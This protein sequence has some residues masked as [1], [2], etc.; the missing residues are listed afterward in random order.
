M[1]LGGDGITGEHPCQLPYPLLFRQKSKRRLGPSV[2]DALHNQKVIGAPGSYLRQV[3]DT[4]DL[5]MSG[6]LLDLS[7][8]RLCRLPSDAGIDFVKDNRLDHIPPG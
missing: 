1:G 3:G 6:Q 8:N 7:G 4:E 5:M 2:F